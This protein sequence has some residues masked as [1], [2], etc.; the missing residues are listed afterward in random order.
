MPAF[1]AANWAGVIC[2]ASSAAKPYCTP[3]LSRTART[4]PVRGSRPSWFT[5]CS[6][7]PHRTPFGLVSAFQRASTG[8]AASQLPVA[9][10]RLRNVRPQDTHV[11]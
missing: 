6:A 2:P 9:V 7:A 8:I 3:S 4:K 1:S 10:E 5:H 11:L